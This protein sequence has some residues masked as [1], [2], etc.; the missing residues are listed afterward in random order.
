[1]KK[2]FISDC[3]GPISKNDNAFELTSNFITKGDK[4]F[5]TISKYDDVQADAFKRPHYNAG[6]T[7]K[8]IL[9]FLKA[10]GASDRAIEN[11][12]RQNLVL[13]ENIRETLRHVKRIAHAYIVSTSYEHYLRALCQA[14]DFPF[15]HTF[16]TRLNIDK[17]AITEAEKD[18]LKRLAREIARMPM[19]Q[20]PENAKK[21]KDFSETDR[22][23]IKRLDEI[24]W[25][26]IPAME[27]G[28]IYEVSPVGGKE[29][30]GAV[31][32]IATK[33]NSEL[34][35]VLYVGDSITDIEAFKLMKE[36]N[37]FAVS[38][39]GNQYAVE[40]AELAIMSETSYATAIIADIF[41]KLGKQKALELAEKWSLKSLRS[42]Q[43]DKTLLNKFFSLHLKT[44]PT[45]KILTRENMH[46]LAEESAAF[47]KKVRGKAI[48]MLG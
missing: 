24:F 33:L 48:G 25:K 32:K 22:K 7:L 13:I 35:D 6:D 38:F 39:N 47:R 28:K 5:T 8:L 40:N 23:T 20:I 4:F 12:S 10:H 37:G 21:M 36:N 31:K 17:Y 3:E 18:Q 41:C 15:E 19:I 1:V 44:F 42:S 9:P 14:L 29:K 30:A 16:C 45:V 26:E 46:A 27:V 11:Y 2:I 34:S 43:V